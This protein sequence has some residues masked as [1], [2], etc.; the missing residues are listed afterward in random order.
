MLRSFQNDGGPVPAGQNDSA[1]LPRG[2]HD[3]GVLAFGP[4]GKLYVAVGD[5][6]RRGA[7]AEPQPGADAAH[8]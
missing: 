6:G 8:G 1:Q 5:L 7:D 4:D 3:G 2:N